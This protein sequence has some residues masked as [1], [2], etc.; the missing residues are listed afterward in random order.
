MKTIT[1][2]QPWASLIA[3][4]IKCVENRTWATKYRGDLLIHA[5]KGLQYKHLLGLY[6]PDT[7]LLFGGVVAKVEIYDCVPIS[8]VKLMPFAGGPWCWLFRNAEPLEFIKC[9]GAQG[10]WNFSGRVVKS[11]HE[12]LVA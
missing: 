9:S 8:E 4:G 11:K 7:D 5:G 12:R 1:I 3:Q 2:S 10:L 6:C